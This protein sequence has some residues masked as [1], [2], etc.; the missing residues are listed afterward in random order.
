VRI[1]YLFDGMP[2]RDVDVVPE[3]KVGDLQY[4]RTIRQE[5]YRVKYVLD[6]IPGGDLTIV[7]LE[8]T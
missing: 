5:P 7:G 4:L 6:P 8:E 2:I 1:R 3:P